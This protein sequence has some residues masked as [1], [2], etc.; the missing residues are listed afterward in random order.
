[1]EKLALT[2]V[3]A[4]RKLRPYFQAHTVR[5]LTE[6]P[7]RKVLQKLD[8]SGRLANWAVKLGEFNLEFLPRSAIKGQALPDFIAEFLV[9]VWTWIIY[10]DG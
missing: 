5:V 1:M 9:K 2:L 8:L 6:Y 7:L 10:V 3:I 4:S